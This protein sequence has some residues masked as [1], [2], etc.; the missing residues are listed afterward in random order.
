MYLQIRSVILWSRNSS[1]APREVPFEPGMV[2]VIMGGS[3]TGKSAVIPIV[4]YCFGSHTCAIPKKAIRTACAWFGVLVETKQGQ[5]LFARREPGDHEATNEM[6]V[7]EGAVVLIPRAVPGSNASAADVRRKLDELCGLS[8]LDFAGGEV[9]NSLDYRPSFRDLMAFVFQPQNVVANRDVLFYRADTHEHREKLRRNILPYVL[10]AVTPEILATQHE[11]ERLRRD[12]R[13]KERDFGKAQKASTRWE[14]EMAGQLARA[15]ELGLAEANTAADMSQQAMLDLLRTVARKTV[16]DFQADS[17]T[18][19][20]AVE[21]LIALEARETKLAEEVGVLKSRQSELGRLREG[22][23]NYREALL[24]QR[25]R[26]AVSDWLVGQTGTSDGCPICGSDLHPELAKVEALRGSLVEIEATAGQLTELPAAVDREVQQIRQH[27]DEAAEQLAAIRRQKRVLTQNSAQAQSRQFQSLG[28]AHYLGQL[29]QALV[30][31]DEVSD[32][33]DLAVEV[34]DLRRRVAA[35]AGKVD[36]AEIERLKEAALDRISGYIARFMPDLDNDHQ[37]DAARLVI[38][39][40]TLRIS[41]TEGESYLWNI[42]SGSNWLSYHLATLLAL[43]AFFLD[44]RHS[45]VPGLLVFDQPSQVYFPE[46]MARRAGATR[47]TPKWN[48]DEDS[49]AV[50]AAFELMSKVVSA[51]RGKLQ[52]IVLDH[53]PEAVWGRLQDVTLAANWRAGEKLV[54]AEWPGVGE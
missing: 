36:E 47:P 13:R 24:L 33:G 29:S 19:T 20:Q 16:D 15:Q 14:S 21:E 11:L 35:L 7:L 3:R 1:Y 6:F 50:R 30:L 4:D 42:G 26:L 2:N 51:R 49:R 32:N 46:K 27:V 52:I 23:G 40:L 31:Y 48:N 39:D 22:A 45:P 44:Q 41:A 38:G 9:Q 10:N 8:H 5:K 28:V 25:D 53:A 34:T 18:I 43:Q 37:N 12:L 17:A 54:P